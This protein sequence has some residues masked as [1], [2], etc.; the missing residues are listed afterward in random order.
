MSGYRWLL[1]NYFGGS[2]VGTVAGAG[3]TAGASAVPPLVRKSKGFV[4]RLF[5][6]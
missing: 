4:Q 6:Q 1:R 5:G 2:T 3:L